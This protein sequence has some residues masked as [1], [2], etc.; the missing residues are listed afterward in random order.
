MSHAIAIETIYVEDEHICDGT[1]VLVGPRLVVIYRVVEL[2]CPLEWFIFHW[3][4]LFVWIVHSTFA[5]LS[6]I[7]TW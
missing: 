4:L 6:G 7:H 2:L 1:S 5:G 3:E